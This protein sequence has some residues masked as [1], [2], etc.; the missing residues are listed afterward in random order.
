MGLP[1]IH[2]WSGS[3]WV[4]ITTD[5][6][7]HLQVDTVSS[8]LPAGAATAANQATIIGHIDTLETNQGHC[9]A[10]DGGDWRSLLV[11]SNLFYNLRVAIYDQADKIESKAGRFSNALIGDFRGLVVHAFPAY[12]RDLTH[13]DTAQSAAQSGDGGSGVGMPST[14]IFGWNGSSWDRLRTYG[15]GILKVGRA[16]VGMLDVRKTAVGQAGAPGARVL[17]WINMNPSAGNSVVEL[18][19]ATAGGAAVKYDCFH[20]EKESHVHQFDPPLEFSNGIYLETF[21][22]MTSVVFGYL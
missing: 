19:D 4:K 15:T 18:T 3:K 17:F 12:L 2:G 10:W 16:K 22:N 13:A 5:A 9:W 7:G 1:G 20:T 14:P 6:A 11:E 21:T 8:A